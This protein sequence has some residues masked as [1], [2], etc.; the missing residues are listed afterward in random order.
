MEILK[1]N[2]PFDE[3]L[4]HYY[5][6]HSGWEGYEIGLEYLT[7]AN[8]QYQGKWTLVLLSCDNIAS[9]ML[10]LHNHPIEVIP[11]SGLSV[12]KAAQR[13]KALPKDQ[14]PNCWQRICGIS[15]R[16]FSQMHLALKIENGVLKHVDGVHRLLSYTYF[17]KDDRVQAYVVGQ[18]NSER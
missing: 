7:A 10:P 15:E 8:T 17:Q 3:V 5:Q 2:V 13:L 11:P 18:I 9:A 1:E 14:M 12:S 16:D 4:A 6:E